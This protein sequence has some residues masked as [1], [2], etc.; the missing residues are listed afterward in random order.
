MFGLR[1]ATRHLGRTVKYTPQSNRIPTNGVRRRVSASH[2]TAST[3]GAP[4]ARMLPRTAR[5]RIPE[6]VVRVNG[7]ISKRIEKQ[8][9]RT[10]RKVNRR[11]TRERT[12]ARKRNA[13]HG[14]VK[15]QSRQQ[16]ANRKKITR[17]PSG[18]IGPIVTAGW[19]A[20]CFPC[21]ASATRKTD[22]SEARETREKPQEFL[23]LTR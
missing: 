6:P 17:R 14:R 19:P 16:I 13:G 8:F 23:P 10:M 2:A 21:C 18:R 1:P 22:P 3:I 12:C 7:I 15:N 20:A 4:P 5:Q 11:T 9:A